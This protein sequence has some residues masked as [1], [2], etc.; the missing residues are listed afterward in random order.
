MIKLK[1]VDHLASDRELLIKAASVKQQAW[2]YP[3][4]SQ[5]EWIDKNLTSNDKHAFLQ[6][7]G[8]NVAYL[9]LVDIRF[10]ADGIAQRAYGIGNVCAA[11]KGM[12]YGGKLISLTNDYLRTMDRVGLLFCMPHVEPFYLRYGW[13]TVERGKSYVDGLSADAQV[14]TF[15]LPPVTESL[16]YNGRLF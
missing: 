10:T 8:E 11:K 9:N 2:P 5:L 7:D 15:S 16:I 3:M 12:G 4:D 13:S 14:L 6:V 1:V